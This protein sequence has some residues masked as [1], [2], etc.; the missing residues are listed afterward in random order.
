MQKFFRAEQVIYWE[1]VPSMKQLYSATLGLTAVQ[2]SG[3][4]GFCYFC[5]MPVRLPAPSSHP[6]FHSLFD[7]RIVPQGAAAFLFPLLDAVGKIVAIVEILRATEAIQFELRFADWFANKFRIMHRWLDVPADVH[8]IVAAI[9]ICETEEAFRKS[10]FPQIRQDF[11]A[12][13]FEMWRYQ[14][15]NPIVIRFAS[16]AKNELKVAQAGLVMGPISKLALFN[17]PTSRL[18]GLYNPAVDGDTDDA[19]LCVPAKID[20]VVWCSVVRRAS[21]MVW[22][23]HDELRLKKLTPLLGRA[24]GHCARFEGSKSDLAALRSELSSLRSLISVLESISSTLDPDRLIHLIMENGRSLTTADRCSLFLVNSERDRLI[25]YLQMGLQAAINIP[26]DAGAVGHSVQTRETVNIADAYSSPFFDPT[27]DRESGYQT[28]TIVSVPIFNAQ[29]DVIGCTEMINKSEG[30]FTDWDIKIIQLFNIFC[31]IALENARLYQDSLTSHEHMKQL[32]D[33]AFS[34]SKTEEVKTM[35]SD[36]LEN[37][38]RAVGADRSSFF[39]LKEGTSELTSFIVDGPQFPGTIPID[40]GLAGVAVA[41]KKPV[42]ENDC[43][44]N[45]DFNPAIDVLCG[46]R[47]DSLIALPIVDPSGDVLGVVELLN[48]KGGQFVPKDVELGSAFTTFASVALQSSR[49]QSMQQCTG[50]E[51]ELMKWVEPDER[52]KCDIPAKLVLTEE[53][54]AK[55]LSMNCFS[56]DFKGI[57]HFKECFFFFTLFNFL[58]TFSITS[59][60]FFRFLYEISSLYTG[61]F[62]HNW[63]HACDVTQCIVFMLHTGRVGDKY[64]AWELFVLMVAAICH[65]TNHQGF[66]NV[67]NVKAETPLGILFKDQSVMEMHHITQSI[68]VSDHRDIELFRCFDQVQIKKVWYLFIKIILSS[69]MARHFEPVKKAQAAADAQD[70]DMTNDKFR[71]LGLQL[72]IKVADISNVSRPFELADR[73]C[74]ILNEEFFHQGDLEKESGIGLTSPL[75]DRKTS[76]KPKS[77]IGFY[78]FICLPLYTVVAKLFQPLQVNVNNVRSNLDKWKAL[79]ADQAPPS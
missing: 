67:Y 22:G 48:K 1:N 36:I 79:L 29:G 23:H 21:T 38:K 25:T 30:V 53:E 18:T 42:L 6:S 8:E 32:L 31:G 39:L 72:L 7:G 13:R 40:K 57:G 26:I 28:R 70:F 51:S 73:W 24:L 14:E 69:D 11:R 44:R 62:Y 17:S 58:E 2:S 35:L 34:L 46:Y 68:P 54:R 74:D 3:L 27:T 75:N 71:L 41:T 12:R 78:N 10:V 9:E 4:V 61:T 64:E 15:P 56:P 20:G 33:M 76:N 65:D 19:V 55:V 47:T 60:Q 49:I 37:A 45:Q 59:E 5:K 16:G 66:N 77:Q 52:P 50:V 63:T 43:Y